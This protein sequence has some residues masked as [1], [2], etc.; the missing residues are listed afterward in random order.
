MS[1]SLARQQQHWRSFPAMSWPDRHIKI[2]ALH[3]SLYNGVKL[4]SGSNEID[5]LAEL[6]GN[7]VIITSKMRL[8][9]LNILV[10]SVLSAA[11]FLLL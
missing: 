5:M 11:E 4:N 7:A 6:V 3:A 8:S 9:G 2:P 10:D 1:T